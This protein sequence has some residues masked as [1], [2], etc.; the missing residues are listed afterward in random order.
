MFLWLLSR[1][2][3]GSSGLMSARCSSSSVTTP[4]SSVLRYDVNRVVGFW[5][6]ASRSLLTS[7]ASSEMQ[8]PGLKC[9][10]LGRG[11]CGRGGGSYSTTPLL[12]ISNPCCSSA[13]LSPAGGGLGTVEPADAESQ[14]V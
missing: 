3:G 12:P 2:S 13:L 10:R 8:A 6:N 5:L 1:C 7:M 4:T 9:G 11:K 14:H